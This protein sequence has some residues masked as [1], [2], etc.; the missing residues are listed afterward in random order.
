MSN[1]KLLK[2][3][4][5]DKL[6]GKVEESLIQTPSN[7]LEN[8]VLSDD[9]TKVLNIYD[10][11]TGVPFN[12]KIIDT[13]P[14]GRSVDNALYF[15]NPSKF[16][17]GY[18][19]RAYSGP[20]FAS[21]YGTAGDGIEDDFLNLQ[22]ALNSGQKYVAL[23]DREKY[24]ISQTLV[25]PEGVTLIGNKSQVLNTSKHITLI[26]CSG[27]NIISDLDTY[28]AGYSTLNQN[29]IAINISGVSSLSRIQNVSVINV[30]IFNSGFYGVL[31][32]F[33]MNINCRNVNI[34]GVGYG[35]ILGFSTNNFEVENSYIKNITGNGTLAYGISF[36]RRAVSTSLE[37]FP[38]SSK[39]TV[40]NTKVENNITWEGFDSHAGE[41]I[42]FLNCTAINCKVGFVHVPSGLGN[43]D[44]YAPINCK[45][46]GCTSYGIGTGSGAIISGAMSPDLSEPV[47]YAKNCLINNSRFFNCG[48]AN[49]NISGGII[50]KGT[51]N[52]LINGNILDKTREIGICIYLFNKYYKVS[53]NIIKDTFS[54]IY[55]VA[56]CI[57]VRAGENIGDI[58]NNNT[59]R[60]EITLGS[61]VS[62]TGIRLED[63][64]SNSTN[65]VAGYNNCS[66]N[67][68][69]RFGNNITYVNLGGN[70]NI[71]RYNGDPNGVVQ[72]SKGSICLNPLG[73]I[74]AVFWFKELGS[75]NTGWIPLLSLKSG[76]IAGRPI[77]PNLGTIYY[78]TTTNSPECWNGSSWI[79]IHP[80]LVGN[81]TDIIS[82]DF[83]NI[84]YPFIDYPVGTVVSYYN[85]GFD[86][87]RVTDSEWIKIPTSIVT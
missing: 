40:T 48:E 67:I 5:V 63:I 26:K 56:P 74:G 30:G 70:S 23:G 13:L 10:Q 80:K 76:N 64:P 24:F 14:V 32:E 52:T 68:T 39:C 6:S 35:G 71:I 16:G 57:S 20:V 79:L 11:Y 22:L 59:I 84:N 73:G 33:S 46:D 87:R 4:T 42:T 47:E 7:Q 19:I 60:E 49:N 31:S 78:N 75:G 55:T 44:D 43:I 53:D 54:N 83:L 3:E 17:G 69:E 21:W 15:R 81:T 41:D 82:K 2:V 77:A 37:T 45:I 51:L 72:S 65:I 85:Q 12:A 27:N 8:A 50:I 1:R 9:G 34:N 25:I 61:Y 58:S 62:A 28:G 36:T 38:R 29:G 86:Y 66:T 18:L